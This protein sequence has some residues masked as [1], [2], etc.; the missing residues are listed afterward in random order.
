MFQFRVGIPSDGEREQGMTILRGTI[1]GEDGTIE[2]QHSEEHILP[3]SR[4]TFPALPSL[5]SSRN[6]NCTSS[7]FR[8]AKFSLLQ[9]DPPAM[10][11]TLTTPSAFVGPWIL[12]KW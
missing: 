11:L 5:S 12:R 4:N 8:N 7:P 6:S 1:D 3:T 10:P 9:I 2:V